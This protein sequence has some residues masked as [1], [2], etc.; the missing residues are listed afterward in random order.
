MSHHLK[1][2]LMP[3]TAI[4]GQNIMKKAL[5]LNAVNPTI[6][7][8]LIRGEKGTAKSSAV[9]ALAEVLPSIQVVPG[10]PFSCNP[11]KDDELCELCADKKESR[12]L[13]EAVERRVKV[14]NLPVG[15]TED[16]V[17]GTIDIERALKEGIRALEP[18]ILADAN[19]GILYIDEVN[20]LD[21]HVVDV[22]L[23]AAAMGVS[24][25]EREGISFSHPARFILIGT[26]N[27]EEGELRPQLLDRFGLQVTVEA[28]DDPDERIAIV[29]VAEEHL[30][31]PVAFRQKYE[32]YQS[33]LSK[34]IHQAIKLLPQVTISDEL[35]RKAVEVC[36]E[37][38][39]R[40]H[41][42]EIT[43][44]RAAKTLAALDGR[45]EVNRNDLKEAIELALPHRMRKR[46]FEE[47]KIDHDRLDDLMDEPEPPEEKKED[48]QDPS[49]QQEEE[50]SSS[51][52]QD[53]SSEETPPSQ[54]ESGSTREQVHG[55]GSPVDADQLK[56][57]SQESMDQRYAP[58]RR[59]DTTGA[60][61]RGHYVGAHRSPEKT[62]IAL[63]ATIR[64]VAPY[65]QN[66]KGKG[67]AVVIK[68]DELLQKRRVGKTAT[69]CLFVVDASGSMG[70]EQRMEAA[71]GAIFSLLEDSYKNR[72]RVGM[73]AFRGKGA[74][75]VLPLSSSI[76]LAYSRLR[77][78]PTGGR[79]PLAAGLMKALST[80]MNEKLKYPSLIPMMI[81]IT[82]GRANVSPGGQLKAELV[83][84]AEDFA[85]AG[86]QTLVI[87][88]E[89]KKKGGFGLQLGFCPLIAKYAHG[90]YFRM[91]ELT[92]EG[93]GDMVRSGIPG[94]MAV[95]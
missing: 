52:E 11:E 93:V 44:V 41:R 43:I 90:K 38:G 18:G 69:A 77:E 88:T 60:D 23:D 87:D 66:R 28:L 5:L 29:H 35:V 31:D 34:Q 86:V 74:D 51:E 56:P 19:R 36:I 81:L 82:D 85:R 14:V 71:K 62:D 65:Q 57:A 61:R 54:S 33:D 53:D 12:A 37:L 7:G 72:D 27:P 70:V 49:E 84:A 76:D 17:V 45:N 58:G 63:D 68:P 94:Q 30:A 83:A 20:L 25:V 13:P 78:L 75:L 16:R 55:I 67:M 40:T 24:T 89:E 4:V 92:A 9:R 3:F 32:V 26:M 95:N 2:P 80:L 50:G 22:L 73:I 64:A 15:A 59:F 46:P 48:Q 10:C 6:G 8:V 21:D 42:A 79:T 91:S 39:V 47:P 1:K